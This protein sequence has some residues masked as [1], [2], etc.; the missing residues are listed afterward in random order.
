MINEFLKK[1]DVADFI[2]KHANEDVKKLGLQ[3]PP[4]P[5]WPYPLILDQIK[6]R[7][8]AQKKIPLWT[9]I[10]DVI[11]PPPDIIEQA[12]SSATA[13]YKAGL[14]EGKTM[15]DLTGGAG[16][17]SH[18]FTGHFE[19]VTTVECNPYL[20]S[21]LEHNTSLLTNTDWS[22]ICGSAE[23]YIARMP[24]ASLVYIDPERRNTKK[25]GL[26][27]LEDCNPDITKLLPLLREKT[28]LVLL[29]ASPMLDIS[30]A[31]KTLPFLSAV[32][33]VEWDGQCREV[34]CLIDFENQRSEK[35]IPITAVE[36]NDEG[37]RDRE[38]KFT[39][40]EEQAAEASFGL[41]L[42]YL[43]EPGPAFQKAG[44][45]NTI[46]CKFNLQKL[47]K[48]THLYT[49]SQ[50]FQDFP[51]RSF[52]LCGIF[53]A[54]AKALPFRKANLTVRNF[55]AKAPDLL[56]KLKLKEG[57]EDYLFAC[58]LLDERKVLLHCKKL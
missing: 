8:K 43:Y 28:S 20:A 1:P 10:K 34:L 30:A 40:A 5:D 31:I 42:D 22:V 4:D 33:V 2:C 11:F 36:I 50:Y 7:Q 39:Q 58:T 49:G 52:R 13:T 29:K 45:F 37:N 18:A 44:G 47:H 51:G 3:K 15:C 46:A 23:D 35:D 38:L 26:Y 12:S 24:Y 27:K 19:Q 41:P 54:N 16:V 14:F 32:H 57:G 17:D 53:P 21:V 9:D 56:K 6:S 25:K 55:P 48:H